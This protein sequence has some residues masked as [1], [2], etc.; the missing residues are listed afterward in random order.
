M[1]I[2]KTQ[3]ILFNML[4]LLILAVL[5]YALLSIL[6]KSVNYINYNL[7]ISIIL[8]GFTI[9]Y[10]L[11]SYFQY[12]VYKQW[13]THKEEIIFLSAFFYNAPIGLI[14]I[15]HKNRQITDINEKAI[16]LIQLPKNKII[17]LAYHKIF[18]VAEQYDK[19]LKSDQMI[20]ENHE[21]HLYNTENKKINIIKNSVKIAHGK[22]TRII[23]SFI[24]ITEYKMAIEEMNKAREIAENANKSKSEFLANISHELRTPMNAIIGIS[25][26]LQKY[27]SQNLEKKQ[28]DGLKVI[29]QSGTRLLDLIND[30]LDISKIEAGK[31]TA[32]LAPLSLEKLFFNLKTVVDTL[33]KEKIIK[34]YI[35]KSKH[36]PDQIISDEKKLFQI[37][38]NLL[39][40]SVKF[41]EKG[42]II[43][44]VH[45]IKDR[46]YFEVQDTGIGIDEE[47]L[48]HIFE[49]FY[50]AD[51]SASRK[52]SGTGL[53]LS[54]C[55]KLTSLLGGD[56]EIE[57]KIHE[58]TIV[59][60]HIP[61][62]YPGKKE[63][64]F[65]KPEKH[66]IEHNIPSREKKLILVIDDN[67]SSQYVMKEYLSQNN[68]D[69]IFASDGKSG[70]ELINEQYP[71]F[72]ILDLN[73]NNE[74]SNNIIDYIKNNDKFKD[75][76]IITT[77]ASDEN[78]KYSFYGL[79]TFLR[80]P[81]NEIELISKLKTIE[82]YIDQEVCDILIIGESIDKVEE[83]SNLFKYNKYNTLSVLEIRY[84]FDM[85]EKFIP[86]VIIILSSPNFDDID[87]LRFIAQHSN[88]KIKNA[89]VII[90]TLKDMNEY[91]RNLTKKVSFNFLPAKNTTNKDMLNIVKQKLNGIR[92]INN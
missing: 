2:S 17:G 77:S 18:D 76:P 82:H 36:I 49:E 53:G 80:K 5:C 62:E 61:Y 32:Q 6:Y 74:F 50:Q 23:E 34:F 1:K 51:S 68:Y 39:A 60:F 52:Y 38:L 12:C 89:Y 8:A 84:A 70:L 41:T 45:D 7:L 88:D 10:L 35:R 66:F 73:L 26:M 85:I 21:C 79:N 44:R 43:L 4:L 15:N 83:L 48:E 47:N 57:S 78:S 40:N 28:I 33:I 3:L 31:M 72:I 16:E 14:I 9:I 91:R 56:I 90:N 59:R 86:A 54:L 13:Q 46:L 24:D 37:L 27:D 92:K 55:K 25:K 42:R 58:G 75:I 81:I 71:N 63:E 19:F 64:L 67:L 11:I 30:V 65:V 69:V 20:L 22:E 29:Y 87:I